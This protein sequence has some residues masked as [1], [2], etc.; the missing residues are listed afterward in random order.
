MGAILQKINSSQI[1]GDPRQQFYQLVNRYKTQV[2][3]FI[4]FHSRL[5]YFQP[6]L[7]VLHQPLANP[8]QNQWN[9]FPIFVTYH[10]SY[11]TN[12]YINYLLLHEKPP[13]KQNVK[14]LSIICIC[15]WFW[16]SDLNCVQRVAFFFFFLIASFTRVLYKLA[17]RNWLSCDHIIYNGHRHVPGLCQLSATASLFSSFPSV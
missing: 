11:A 5:K 14:Q 8:S 3:S 16:V 17:L 2:K 15:L 9:I 7:R 13:Q 10:T 6:L 12:F 1:Q 4:A